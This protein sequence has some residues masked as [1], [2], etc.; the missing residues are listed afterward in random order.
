M[1]ICRCLDLIL[2][3]FY[4]DVNSGWVGVYDALHC[5]HTKLSHVFTIQTIHAI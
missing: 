1:N 4:I 5:I 3:H 2:M